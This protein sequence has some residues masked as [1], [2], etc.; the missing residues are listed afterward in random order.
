MQTVSHVP[1]RIAS[2]FNISGKI[3]VVTGGG[4]G[5]GEM[6]VRGGGCGGGGGWHAV[7]ALLSGPDGAR[8]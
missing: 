8:R 3:A 4:R 6:I 7:S 2:L 5:I 1:L